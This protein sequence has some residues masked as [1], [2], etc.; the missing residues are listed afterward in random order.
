[1]SAQVRP[2]VLIAALFTL[3]VSVGS[4]APADRGATFT[5]AASDAADTVAREDRFSGVILVARG[6][7]VLLRKAA[8][9]A[10]RERNIPNTPK[11]KFPIYSVT[12]QFT[13]AAI[14]LLVQDGKVSLEDRISK[15]YAASPPAWQDVTIKHLL[16]HGS[17][18][19][20]Y[21]VNH[22]EARQALEDGTL[23]QTHEQ[24]FQLMIGDPLAFAPGTSMS[25]SNAGYGLLT[26]VIERASGQ[27]YEAFLRDRIFVP[28]SMHDTGSGSMTGDAAKGYS[29]SPQSEWQVVNLDLVSLGGA[30]GIYSTLDDMLT[31]SNALDDERLLSVA[32]RTALFTD[33]GFNYGFGWR[34][35]T[36]Y[37]HRLI[38][39]TGNAGPRGGFAAIFNRFPE[40]N[41]TVVVLT[42]NPS[43]I[44]YT[45]TMTVG[46]QPLTFQGNAARKVTDQVEQLYFG[47]AP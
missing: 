36:R 27:L 9:L 32:S 46:G 2:I 19:R 39:H 22:P 35:Q 29:Q 3:F 26:M 31:W 11:T 41:V 1:M 24:L 13:A 45:A 20:D 47:R 37:G 4:A 8:G 23:F 7:Q 34:F 14:M 40:D 25:Y 6:D 33:Y 44:D 17:G 30:G 21:W 12:K 28:L 16:T 42:N 15:Y 43:L 18:I 10:D 5:K 38:W